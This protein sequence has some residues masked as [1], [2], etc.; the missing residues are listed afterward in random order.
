[1]S[2]SALQKTKPIFSDYPPLGGG[3]GRRIKRKT[4]THNNTHQK[5]NKHALNRKQSTKAGKIVEKERKGQ[6][7]KEGRKDGRKAGRKDGRKE[8]QKEGREGKG[9]GKGKERMEGRKRGQLSK[10]RRAVDRVL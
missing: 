4:T 1:M 5:D 7:G 9:K 3:L 2:G 10:L 8:G 6:G